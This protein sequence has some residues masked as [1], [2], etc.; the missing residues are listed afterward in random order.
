MRRSFPLLLAPI[1]TLVLAPAAAAHVTVVPPFVPTQAE[2]RLVLDVP[3]ERL[4]QPMTA[5]EVTVPPG[6]SV[7]SAEP[8][9]AWRG[10]VDGREARWTGGSLPPRASAHFAV[11]VEGPRRAGAVQLR[12]VQRYPDKGTVPWRVDLTITPGEG[13]GG[14]QH[15]GAAALAAVVGLVVIAGSLLVVHRLRRRTLQEG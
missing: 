15:L 9:G 1:L 14:D 12:A 7:R 3:N 6:M 2:T 11:V 10:E 8:L 5:L 13:A 4:I